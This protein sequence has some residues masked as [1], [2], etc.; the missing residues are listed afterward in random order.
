M[1]MPRINRTRSATAPK[2]GS[3]GFL[4]WDARRKSGKSMAEV[5]AACELSQPFLGNVENG[6]RTPALGK[7]PMIAMGY[8]LD[9]AEAIWVWLISYEPTIVR[10][11]ATAVN[12]EANRV[13]RD[14]AASQ[15]QEEQEA[16]KASTKAEKQAATSHKADQGTIAPELLRVDRQVIPDSPLPEGRLITRLAAEQ[17]AQTQAILD[18]STRTEQR[19]DLEKP[20]RFTPVGPIGQHPPEISGRIHEEITEEQNDAEH[21]RADDGCRH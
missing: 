19:F 6:N 13:L 12:Y 14:A 9:P 11:L 20:M 21:S 3:F 4:L 16:K 1:V 10:Y 17:M 18:R 7:V 2:P 8:D 15:Y 5:A